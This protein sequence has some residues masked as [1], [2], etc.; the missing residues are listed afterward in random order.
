MRAFD[1]E[2]AARILDE[3]DDYCVLGPTEAP[4]G[5]SCLSDQPG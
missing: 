4:P 5:Q 3:H 1:P 2:G